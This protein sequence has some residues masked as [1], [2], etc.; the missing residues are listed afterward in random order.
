MYPSQS[1]HSLHY[2]A[3][4]HILLVYTVSIVVQLL[5]SRHHHLNQYLFLSR[6]NFPS[7]HSYFGIISQVLSHL[8]S[9]YL[10]LHIIYTVHLNYAREYD[11]TYLLL[12][13]LMSINQRTLH[14]ELVLVMSFQI[15]PYL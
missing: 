7:F 4:G 3:T 2:K 13:H 6:I 5:D 15:I 8:S 12:H 11:A 9:H 14:Y 1:F 10:S